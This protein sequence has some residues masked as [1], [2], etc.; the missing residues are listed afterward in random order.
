MR[1]VSSF[2]RHRKRDRGAR[3][4]PGHTHLSIW[5]RHSLTLCVRQEE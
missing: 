3:P 1:I 5:S 4:M 2:S